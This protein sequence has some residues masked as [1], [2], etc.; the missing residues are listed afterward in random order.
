M[1]YTNV[2]SNS[3]TDLFVTPLMRR[4]CP[5]AKALNKRLRKIVLKRERT[6]P[7]LNRSNFG[8]W[9]SERDLLDWPHPEMATLRDTPRNL[10]QIYRCE[11]L[12]LGRHAREGQEIS[13]QGL[14][15]ARGVMHPV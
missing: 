11:G 3:I 6:T 8:G 13:D 9:Q 4:N 10:I 14:H 7:A 5:G 12:S 15:A 1:A 2:L